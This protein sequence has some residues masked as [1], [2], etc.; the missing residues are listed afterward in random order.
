MESGLGNDSI[1]IQ[2][3]DTQS[4]IGFIVSSSKWSIRL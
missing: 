3:T 1:M 2:S 4:G